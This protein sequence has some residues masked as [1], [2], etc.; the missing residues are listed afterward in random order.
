MAIVYSYI[1]IH[2]YID[3]SVRPIPLP[4]PAEVQP[5]S[6]TENF[7][8]SDGKSVIKLDLGVAVEALGMSG[9]PRGCDARASI[10]DPPG[11]SLAGWS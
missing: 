10:G 7:S 5:V 11:A 4:G 1:T 6:M 9:R 8:I 3:Q 2:L